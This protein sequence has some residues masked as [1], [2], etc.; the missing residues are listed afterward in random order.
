M[1]AFEVAVSYLWWWW[2]R[3]W[4]WIVFVVWLTDERRLALFLAGTIA[5]D[6]HHH[7]SLT[8]REQDFC[9]S[10]NHYTTVLHNHYI[11]AI[12]YLFLLLLK[13]LF[14]RKLFLTEWFGWEKLNKALLGKTRWP[15]FVFTDCSSIQF[16]NSDPFPK[17]VSA[18]HLLPYHSVCSTLQEKMIWH[19]SPGTSH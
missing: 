13:W 4:W 19:W 15:P 16:F 12:Y 6:L 2:C 18:Q 1:L 5:R 14:P 9:S 7:E 10:D 8:R 3:W 17:T 11:T